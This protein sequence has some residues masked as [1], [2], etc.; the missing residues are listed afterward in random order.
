IRRNFKNTKPIVL[1]GIEASL[2]RVTHYDFWSDKLRRSILLDAKADYLVYGMGE[3]A[4][5]EI[6]AKLKKKKSAEQVKGVC[7][8]S[9]KPKYEY[10]QLPSFEDCVKSKGSFTE[11][12]NMFYQNNDPIT[13]RG[14]YQQTGER[15]LIQNP[16]QLYIFIFRFIG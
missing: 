10:I 11:M 8:L 14:L 7:Y 15:Y 3:K 1:G 13:A 2:R 4:I 16:P 9:D 6:A 5:L 12:F